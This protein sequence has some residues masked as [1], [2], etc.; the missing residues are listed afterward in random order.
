M[1]GTDLEAALAE[2]GLEDLDLVGET[3]RVPGI[4]LASPKRG[5][6]RG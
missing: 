6:K 4:S 1:R 5:S 2:H 3:L